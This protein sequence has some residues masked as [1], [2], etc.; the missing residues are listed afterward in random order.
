[1]R[2]RV[3][4]AT[5]I[6]ALLALAG[7]FSV[8][9]LLKR[10]GASCN[11]LPT[12]QQGTYSHELTS[13]DVRRKYGLGPEY[14]GAWQLRLTGCNYAMFNDDAKVDEGKYNV[15]AHAP[16]GGEIELHGGLCPNQDRAPYEY[17]LEADVL[18]LER[19]GPDDCP[20]R[21]ARLVVEPWMRSK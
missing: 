13:D 9:Y 14:I 2:S 19:V 20:G 10:T 7:A 3:L 15:T 11:A 1:M 21:I 5:A 17:R 16:H 8:A 4:A 18:I 6:S 12:R